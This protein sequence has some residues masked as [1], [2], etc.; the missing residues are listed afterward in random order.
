MPS[1]LPLDGLLFGDANDDGMVAGL[2]LTTAQQNFGNVLGSAAAAAAAVAAVPE[3]TSACL[4]TLV[5]LGAMARR[6]RLHLN[7]CSS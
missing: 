1:G 3:S 6:R 5:S 7:S 4:L 2:D